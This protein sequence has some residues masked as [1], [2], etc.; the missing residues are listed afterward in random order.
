MK[1][2][3]KNDHEVSSEKDARRRNVGFYKHFYKHYSK[4]LMHEFGVNTGHILLKRFKKITK[5]EVPLSG[6]ILDIGCGDGYLSLNIMQAN[7]CCEF[8][9][10]DLS[11]DM[12]RVCQFRALDHHLEI[13]LTAGDVFYLPFKNE[14]F[15]GIIAQDIL[16][17]LPDT[18]KCFAEIHRILKYPGFFIDLQ[19]PT[20]QGDRHY[21][22]LFNGIMQIPMQL[23]NLTKKIIGRTI[24]G[25]K[26]KRGKIESI[27]KADNPFKKKSYL[28]SPYSLSRTVEENNF[29]VVGIYEFDFLE[30]IF[31]SLVRP[32]IS[33]FDHPKGAI[34][35]LINFIRYVLFLI[36][37]SLLKMVLPGRFLYRILIYLRKNPV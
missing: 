11:W 30:N 27:N 25:K 31:V 9:G 24:L 12:L 36:D 8:F 29:E 17:H 16:H 1:D 26:V 33:R 23:N 28:L 3:V 37:I 2:F 19:E 4:E 35:S 18:S 5:K 15:D 34:V 13:K 7:R 6:K 21:R 14:S 22:I 32:I 20:L 10:M